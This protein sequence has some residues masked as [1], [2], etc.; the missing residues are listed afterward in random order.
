MSDTKVLQPNLGASRAIL[1][2]TLTIRRPDGSIRVQEKIEVHPQ[3]QPTPA[4]PE[5]K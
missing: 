1:T 2:G 4:K 3:E 5:G